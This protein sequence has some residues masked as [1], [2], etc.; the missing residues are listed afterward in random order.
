MVARLEHKM[1]A[2]SLLRIINAS[3]K[4]TYLSAW[5][6]RW[7]CSGSTA[8]LPCWLQ[9]YDF[10]N[11]IGLNY[12]FTGTVAYFARYLTGGSS[13]GLATRLSSGLSC[14]LQRCDKANDIG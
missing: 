3:C 4:E 9:R 7:L 8:G 14:W 11:D 5:L 13:D 1:Y 2:K 12:L 6:P 10:K